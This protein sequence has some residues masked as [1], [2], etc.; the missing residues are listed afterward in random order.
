MLRNLIDLAKR[1]FNE[2]ARIRHLNA[3]GSIYYSQGKF[4]L[5]IDTLRNAYHLVNKYQFPLHRI[6][7]LSNMALAHVALAE[8]SIAIR[9]IIEVR[10]YAEKH[11][12][13]NIPTYHYSIGAGAFMPLGKL[14][15]V[16]FHRYLELLK[17]TAEKSKNIISLGHMDLKYGDYYYFADQSNDSKKHYLKSIDIFRTTNAKDDM[18]EALLKLS[19]VHRN[20]NDHKM[21]HDYARQ[22]AKIFREINCGYLKP[23]YSYVMALNECHDDPESLAPMLEAIN[24][25]RA[26]GTRE[27]TWQIQFHLARLYREAGDISNSVKYCRES[28]NTLKEITESFDDP[29]QTSSY[30]QVPL[31]RQVFDFVKSLRS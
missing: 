18:L 25:S 24:V 11:K 28:I 13:S 3:L 16:N 20:I 14:Q 10:S 6:L 31:R 30:L 19:L 4:R 26:F 1:S 27:W 29:D 22:A 8:Y 12:L 15:N 23:L 17:E 21:A 2:T 5:Q 9:L 7:T